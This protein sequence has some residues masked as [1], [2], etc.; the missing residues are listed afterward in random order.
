LDAE[1]PLDNSAGQEIREGG[2]TIIEGSLTDPS[3]TLKVNAIRRG[4]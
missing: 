4:E 2:S 1:Y 3:G